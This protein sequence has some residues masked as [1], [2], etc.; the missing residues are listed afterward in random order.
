MQNSMVIFVFNLFEIENTLLGE[1]GPKKLWTKFSLS[2]EAEIGTYTN[3]DMKNSMML[4]F[5]SF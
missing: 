4:I 3:S 5:F 2:A 1:F